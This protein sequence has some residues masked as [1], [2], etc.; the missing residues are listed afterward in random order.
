[1]FGKKKRQGLSWEYIK[2]K[3]PEIIEELKTLRNWD[4][5]RSAIPESESIG[6]YSLLSL[7]AIAALIMELRVEKEMLSERLDIL[8]KKLED[9]NTAHRSSTY[10]MEKRMNELEG[11][12]A[13]LEKRMIFLDSMENILPRMGELESRI[14]RL[15]SEIMS[16]I[17]HIYGQKIDDYLNRYIEA[18][19]SEFEKRLKEDIFGVS[20]DL[21]ETLRKIQERYEELVVE[22]LELK[23]IRDENESLKKMLIE[24]EKEVEEL[25]RQIRS[26]QELSKKVEELNSK[27][28]GYRVKMETLRKLENELKR[29]TGSESVE[30][31]LQIIRQQMEQKSKFEKALREVKVLLKDLEEIKE[32]NQRLR[33]E[34]ERLRDALKMI[35]QEKLD[36]GESSFSENTES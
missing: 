13:D 21:A 8:G 10:S 20:V 17:E 29:L 5:V 18:R 31:A 9:L 30:T 24:K 23:K 22:N 28:A 26:L 2:S 15:P 25:R 32:E 16:Q 6:D 7:E 27:V 36:S 12:L 35:L 1:M 19:L 34:N 3:H 4:T 11:S 14:E 33:N